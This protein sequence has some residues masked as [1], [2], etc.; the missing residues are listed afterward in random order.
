M[1]T[2]IADQAAAGNG[3]HRHHSNCRHEGF[4]QPLPHG[5]G[6]PRISPFSGEYY[7][8]N[9]ELAKGIPYFEALQQVPGI[10]SD[11]YF[12]AKITAAEFYYAA[13]ND[14]RALALYRLA[15]HQIKLSQPQVYFHYA[16]V[17]NESGA[18]DDAIDKLAF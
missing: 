18:T 3:K 11:R 13:D 7:Q 17:L 2:G 5:A 4:H 9:H 1:D 15:D 8:Q 6:G 14:A 12:Q 16:V 10:D